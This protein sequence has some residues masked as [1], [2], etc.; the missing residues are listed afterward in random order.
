MVPAFVVVALGADA[1][2]SLIYSQVVLSFALPVPMI[3]LVLLSGRR[4]VMGRFV[5][6][7]MMTGCAAAA[8]AVVLGLNVLLLLQMA[9]IEL[10]FF[11]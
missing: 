3:A 8:S 5:S 10:P 7:P 4:S 11:G 1:T 2:Q 6:S 9:G